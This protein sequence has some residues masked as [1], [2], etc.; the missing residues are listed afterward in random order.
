MKSVFDNFD[1]LHIS[2]W[3]KFFEFMVQSSSKEF[4]YKRRG[5][6]IHTIFIW[7]FFLLSIL[8]SVFRIS[9]KFPRKTNAFTKRFAFFAFFI[10]LNLC[11]KI[12]WK[13]VRNY[14]AK[15]GI[16]WICENFL[17]SKFYQKVRDFKYELFYIYQFT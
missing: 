11:N 3:N 16:R 1:L 17:V 5:C 8:L 7:I 9:L 14:D 2:A 6:Y 12:N 15:I 10:K 13:E 4:L